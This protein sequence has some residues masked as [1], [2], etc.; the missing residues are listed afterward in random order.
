MRWSIRRQVPFKQEELAH[1]RERMLVYEF[2]TAY[3]ELRR[4]CPQGDLVIHLS[5]DE[6]TLP[7][8]GVKH[9]ATA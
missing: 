3:K 5:V 1:H 9:E 2:M 7:P 4:S 6:F 8:M